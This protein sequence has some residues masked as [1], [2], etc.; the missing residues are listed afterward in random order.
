[1]IFY[2]SIRLIVYVTIRT[3]F[4]C[5]SQISLND[6]YNRNKNYFQ[7]NY[8]W[9]HNDWL[10]LFPIIQ[11]HSY[12]SGRT[13]GLIWKATSAKSIFSIIKTHLLCISEF[14]IRLIECWK[15]FISRIYN[16]NSGCNWSSPYTRTFRCSLTSCNAY[17]I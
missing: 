17:T 3:F 1:M 6:N 13:V 10:V 8:L 9:L 7:M 14:C 2:Q 12:E 5:K 16:R 4:K 11:A 15:C